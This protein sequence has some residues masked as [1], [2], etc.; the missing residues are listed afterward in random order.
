MQDHISPSMEGSKV[1]TYLVIFKCLWSRAINI[2]VVTA[3]DAKTFILA[4]NDHI[5]TYGIPRRIYSDAGSV[6]QSA[7]PYI[8]SVLS[9]EKIQKYLTDRNCEICSFNVN[10][11][12]SLNRGIGGFIE[13]AVKLVKRFI[14]G[15]IRNN[16]LDY[17]Q[18]CHVVRQTICYCNKRPLFDV[19]AL[20]EQNPFDQI[21][22]F[23]P[24]LLKLEYE[25]NVIELTKIEDNF[26]VN[27][28]EKIEWTS[29][30]QL[31]GIKSKLREQY[32]DEFVRSLT[33]QATLIKDRY[34]PKD[35]CNLSV[36]D[37][38]LIRDTFRESCRLSNGVCSL[39][40]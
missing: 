17:R 1:K 21:E 12:E 23:T 25:T 8:S 3:A 29:F 4:L 27:T 11:K 24:E 7:F 31:L 16:I 22:I 14:N 20:R 26:E 33:V 38:V 18:F 37:I 13:S 28:L 39:G 30:K 5:Y 2:E 36:G 9:D 10:P 6:F 19:T 34:A 35:H 15:A 32:L 40:H